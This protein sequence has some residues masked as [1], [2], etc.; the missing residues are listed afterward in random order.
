M[1]HFANPLRTLFIRLWKEGA[2][3]V[4]IRVVPVQNKK[5]YLETDFKTYKVASA[6]TLI[7][8]ARFLATDDIQ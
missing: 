5:G 8:P 2:C 1:S 7:E 4:V 3:E 6:L